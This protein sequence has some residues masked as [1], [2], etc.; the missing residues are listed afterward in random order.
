MKINCDFS[1]HLDIQKGTECLVKEMKKHKVITVKAKPFCGGYAASAALVGLL[2]PL[3]DINFIRNAT[4]TKH[5]IEKLVRH[6]DG[7][8]IVVHNDIDPYDMFSKEKRQIIVAAC[9]QLLDFENIKP[10]EV[11]C[12]DYSEKQIQVAYL[13]NG[14]VFVSTLSIDTDKNDH[15]AKLIKMALNYE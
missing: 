11:Y 10:G 14:D 5:E 7:K 6:V 12:V 3:D 2:S 13:D 15:L 4:N 9:V 8:L 1:S